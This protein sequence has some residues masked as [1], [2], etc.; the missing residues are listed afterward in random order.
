MG[1]SANQLCALLLIWM[2]LP[3]LRVPGPMPDIHLGFVAVLLLVADNIGRALIAGRGILRHDASIRWFVGFSVC[4]ALSLLI[5]ATRQQGSIA[6][7]DLT[8]LARPLL[9]ALVFLLAANTKLRTLD[10]D[11]V[12]RVL[13]IA[14]LVSALFGFAQYFDLAGINGVVSPYYAPTQMDGLLLHQRI[15]G[16]TGNPNEFG[17]LMV[18]ASA[19]AL[20]WG[21]FSNRLIRKISS[22]ILVGVFTSAMILTLS[23]SALIVWAIAIGLA[24]FAIYPRIGGSVRAIHGILFVAIVAVV[25]MALLPAGI[26]DRAAGMANLAM[27]SSWQARLGKWRE[28][29]V[30][31]QRFPILGW[32]PAETTMLSTVDNEWILVLRRYGLLGMS[33]FL[34]LCLSLYSAVARVGRRR[35][36]RAATALSVSLQAVLVGYAVYMIPASV[37]H[38]LQLMPILL[39]LVGLCLSQWGQAGRCAGM[40]S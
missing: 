1:I 17:A 21:F 5:S 18:L 16:T 28:A 30:A 22:L 31:W 20:G 26:F 37:Y 27:D 8:E 11:R 6:L 33:V 24:L 7:R 12:Y 35:K 15:T 3:P 32:G 39:L 34:C 40:P 14:F 10:M 4:V 9:Y 13:L 2:L 19:L 29:L 25:V 23:R 36:G 38:S